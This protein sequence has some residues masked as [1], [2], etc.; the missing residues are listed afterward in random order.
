[1]SVCPPAAHTPQLPPT[2]GSEKGAGGAVA[3]QKSFSA[4]ISPRDG[5]YTS[6]LAGQTLPLSDAESFPAL[7]E[8]GLHAGRGF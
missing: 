3:P 8:P 2:R 7:A 6:C 4:N 5:W 1:M